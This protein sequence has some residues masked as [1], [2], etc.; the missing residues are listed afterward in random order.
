M[1]ACFGVYA[2]VPTAVAIAFAASV[3]PPM[4]A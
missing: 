1:T 3:N 2:R 4:N